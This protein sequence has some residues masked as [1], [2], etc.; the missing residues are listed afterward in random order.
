MNENYIMSPDRFHQL[1]NVYGFNKHNGSTYME[2]ITIIRPNLPEDIKNLILNS[3]TSKE[4]LE[5]LEDNGIIYTH[6]YSDN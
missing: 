3:S 6:K 5:L 4:A 1:R 2:H